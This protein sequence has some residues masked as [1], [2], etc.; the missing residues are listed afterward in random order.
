MEVNQ[1]IQELEN[2]IKNSQII[3]KTLREIIKL[4]SN[5]DENLF[6]IKDLIKKAND[7]A[8]NFKNG[9]FLWLELLNLNEYETIIN[10][11]TDKKVSKFCNDLANVLLP[12]GIN[13]SG[14][15]PELKAG[16]FTIEIDM[17][18]L[19]VNLWYG[20][21]QEN[22]GKLPFSTEKIF[23]K[24]RDLKNNLGTKLSEQQFI[25]K[26]HQAYYRVS[27]TSSNQKAPIIKVMKEL[28]FLIQDKKFDIDP[29]KDNYKSYSRMNFSY[30][31]FL[32]R[33]KFSK[34]SSCKLQPRLIVA[35]REHTKKRS[36]FLWIPDNE[37][38]SGTVYSDIQFMEE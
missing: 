31:L 27:G 37:N 6:K 28:A 8:R 16:L 10:T 24:I 30:D 19:K 35:T 12:L 5:R 36:N 3:N 7:K 22:L 25:E 34:V 9:K 4:D 11:L 17:N 14:Q 20:P 1:I 29:T 18:S 15:L 13:L 21:K 32:I 38:G 26:L 23:N 2:Y 33:N